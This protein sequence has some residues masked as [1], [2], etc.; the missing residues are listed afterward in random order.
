MEKEIAVIESKR[1]AQIIFSIPVREL[2]LA[3]RKVSIASAAW[4]AR[5]SYFFLEGSSMVVSLTN[6]AEM[7]FITQ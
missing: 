1:K 5:K 3:L 7:L 2:R 4:G 6:I